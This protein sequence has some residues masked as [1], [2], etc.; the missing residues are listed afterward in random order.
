MTD[1]LPAKNIEWPLLQEESQWKVQFHGKCSS[2]ALLQ[3]PYIR[4]QIRALVVQERDQKVSKASSARRQKLSKV[5]S[6]SRA[7]FAFLASKSETSLQSLMICPCGRSIMECPKSGMRGLE[8]FLQSRIVGQC[9]FLHSQSLLT[10]QKACPI[11]CG[12]Y[13]EQLLR[14]CQRIESSSTVG[15]QRLPPTSG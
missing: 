5:E 2:S 13:L 4:R 3:D 15:P 9:Q 7:R 14:S 8:R 10:N 11:Q 1:Q 6:Y 12:E